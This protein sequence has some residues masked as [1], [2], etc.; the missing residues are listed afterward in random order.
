LHKDPLTPFVRNVA[1][2]CLKIIRD[3]YKTLEDARRAGDDY[4]NDSEKEALGWDAQPT[5][6]YPF[7]ELKDRLLDSLDELISEIDLK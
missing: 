1:L 5:Y 2:R 4:F 3:D 6:D 7:E